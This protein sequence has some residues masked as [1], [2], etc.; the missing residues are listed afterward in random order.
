MDG[1]WTPAQPI[2]NLVSVAMDAAS[3][4]WAVGGGVIAHYHDGAWTTV[5]PSFPLT[6]IVLTGVVM[7]SRSEGWA[8]GNT[9]SPND[10]GG[11]PVV[12]Q[13]QNGQWQL[14]DTPLTTQDTLAA[15]ALASPAEG[16]AMGTEGSASVILHYT[17][18]NGWVRVTTPL[19]ITFHGVSMVSPTDGWAVG[20]GNNFVHYEDGAW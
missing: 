16:W 12:L 14:A 4:G 20:E 3:D 2:P 19:K 17:R 18:Q 13:Y 7:A 6:G 9:E 5:T 8:I 11:P 15:I 1:T 10:S